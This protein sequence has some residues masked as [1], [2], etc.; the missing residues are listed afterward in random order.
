MIGRFEIVDSNAARP[1]A[2]RILFC[3]GSG[4]RLFREGADLELSHWRPNRTPREYRADTSTGICFRFLDAPQGGPWTV[5]INNHLDVDGILSV[6]VLVHSRHALTERETII[7]AAEMGDFWGWGERKAQRLFQGLTRLMDEL[8]PRG[9]VPREIYE[10]AFGRIPELI[11]RTDSETR[12]IE[13]SLEPLTRGVSLVEQGAIVRTQHGPRFAHYVI[14]LSVAG[15]DDARA[16][17]V[18]GFNEAISEKAVLWPQARARWDDERVCV[19]S[20]ERAGGWFH[21]V[22]FPG[23]L[24]ADTENRWL[25]PGMR[26]HDGMESYD[27][28]H[29]PLADALARLQSEEK[30]E[31]QWAIGNGASP[32]H[33][34]LQ[35]QFPV[36]CRFADEA[37]GAALSQLPPRQVAEALDGVFI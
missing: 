35:S 32:F 1:A 4:G 15:E 31:G 34:A 2:E 8:R 20:T 6:Y 22:W 25:V 18:P 33:H 10:R 19:V 27:L 26:Y 16:S 12:A 29:P 3:D 28:N 7:S 5:A 9:V 37:G 21:A 17:Y 23:Y 13:A 11:D 24:W 30:G 14:P 36:V